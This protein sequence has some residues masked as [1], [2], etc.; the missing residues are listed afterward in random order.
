MA[1]ALITNTIKQATSLSESPVT[2]PS[3]NTTGANLIVI[4]TVGN[5][6]YA[7]PTDSQSNTWTLV[8]NEATTIFSAMYYCFNPTTSAT[9]TF[10]VSTQRAL[11]LTVSAWS[12]AATSPLDKISS[13]QVSGVNGPFTHTSV[14]PSTNNQLCVVSLTG[15]YASNGGMIINGGFTITDTLEFVG[16]TAYAN[17]MAYLIQTAAAASAPAWNG[18]V[19]VYANV[20]ALVQG[21]FIAS[22]T[23]TPSVT[24]W[25]R[26]F[27]QPQY[28]TDIVSV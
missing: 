28:N 26:G 4:S 23:T 13:N 19:S 14:T 20:G 9:H 16:G 18:A 22:T 17:A 6:G 8:D 25:F 3:V 10:S 2:T 1:F 15:N 27:P 11:C 12:G 5:D 7:A 21:T 24:T